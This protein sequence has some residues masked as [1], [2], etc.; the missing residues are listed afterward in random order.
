M[1]FDEVRFPPEIENGITGGPTF[2]TTV[3]QGT[4]GF[5]QRNQNWKYERGFWD[6]SNAIKNQEEL[7]V[8]VAFWNARLGPLRG[9]RFKDWLDYRQDMT[10]ANDWMGFGEIQIDNTHYQL[11]KRHFDTGDSSYVRPI[12]KPLQGTMQ[13]R[14]G[15]TPLNESPTPLPAALEFYMDYATGIVEFGLSSPHTLGG[16]SWKG[17]FDVPVRFNNDSMAVTLDHYRLYSWGQIAMVEI[18]DVV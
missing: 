14:I 7:N 10:L 18:R 9:F 11:S 17:E 1:A 2:S 4:Q 6:L 12:R 5:E 8:L 3:L 13:V 16:I 15:A